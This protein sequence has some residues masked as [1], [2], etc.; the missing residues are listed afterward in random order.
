MILHSLIMIK[1]VLKNHEATY[2][3]HDIYFVFIQLI[4]NDKYELAI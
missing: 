3:F 2:F 1:N 4:T